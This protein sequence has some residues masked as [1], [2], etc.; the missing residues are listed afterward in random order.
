M[1]FSASGNQGNGTNTYGS[2]GFNPSVN[3]VVTNAGFSIVYLSNT[4]SAGT[5]G[6]GDIGSNNYY[7][8]PNSGGILELGSVI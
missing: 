4:D 3:S 1:G 2:L 8:Q 7:M 5:L 6:C